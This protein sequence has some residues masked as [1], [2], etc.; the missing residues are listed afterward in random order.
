MLTASSSHFDPLRNSAVSADCGA[1]LPRRWQRNAGARAL[2][3]PEGYPTWH[4]LDSRPGPV[5]VRHALRPGESWNSVRHGTAQR[6]SVRSFS[7]QAPVVRF[8]PTPI[9]GPGRIDQSF[10][11]RAEQTNAA[12]MLTTVLKN[13]TAAAA[14]A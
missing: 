6:T 9:T 14:Y 7:L 3:D 13:G 4:D 12:A 1:A 8:D 11:F 2:G 10:N 5:Q